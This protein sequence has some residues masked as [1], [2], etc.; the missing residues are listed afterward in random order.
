MFKLLT[1]FLLFFVLVGIRNTTVLAESTN[2]WTQVLQLFDLKDTLPEPKPEN[3][4]DFFKW[5]SCLDSDFDNHPIGTL[6]QSE[7]PSECSPDVLYSWGNHYK[8]EMLQRE[9]GPNNQGWNRPFSKEIYTHINPVAT[10]GYGDMAFRF[11]LKPNLRYFLYTED[12][13]DTDDNSLCEQFSRAEQGRTIVVRTWRAGNSS[14]VDYLLCSPQAIES[15]STNTKNHYDEIINAY[16]WTQSHP[17]DWIP[18]LSLRHQPVLF[19]PQVDGVVWT[20]DLLL[21]KLQ[22]IQAKASSGQGLIVYGPGVPV[23]EARH[24]KTQHPSYWNP[25]F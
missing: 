19:G 12:N 10:S 22:S 3:G 20:P 6:N 8:L 1:S 16:Q 23:D 25:I 9:A 13:L 21:G 24:F 5:R 17:T 18:Y 11:K 15:W 2:P 14:G 7:L 4:N